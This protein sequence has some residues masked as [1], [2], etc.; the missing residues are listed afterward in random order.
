MILSSYDMPVLQGESATGVCSFILSKLSYPDKS[1]KNY[2]I[3]Y[4]K[5]LYLRDF[6]LLAMKNIRIICCIILCTLS[7]HIMSADNDGKVRFTYD[8]DFEM[9]FD[10]REYY[11]SN[12]SN[13]MTIFGARLTPSAGITVR[14]DSKMIHKVMGGIDIMKDFGASISPVDVTPEHSPELS[15][16][17]LNTNLFRELVLYYGMNVK[18]GDNDFSMYAGIF[19]RRFSDGSYSTAFFSDSLKFYDNNFEGLLL[20]LKRPKAY[21]ELGCDW[22]GQYGNFRREKFMVFSSGEGKVSPMLS[23]GYSAYMY[24]FACSNDVDGV[25]DNMLVNP[26]ARLELGPKVGFQELSVTLGW[27]Q[28]L[29]HDRKNVGHYV[30][31]GGGELKTEIKKWN[32]GIRNSLFW[33]DDMMPY[34]NSR[35]EGGFTYGERLYMGDP[36]YRINDDGRIGSGIYDMLEIYYEPHLGRFLEIRIG[37]RFHFHSRGYSGCQQIVNLRF[38]LHE[39]LER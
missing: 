25:V 6:N 29:Q 26:Y 12:F 19:P 20:K 27:L 36:F 13:S 37:A 5:V 15:G 22:M 23:L 10:N 4:T 7:H 17:Q 38:N 30:F 31:P 1:I 11:S 16:N 32:A 3:L 35:D 14:Q 33:G 34:Y 18:S 21:F 24:H 9:N 39:M 28:G 2:H 8:V